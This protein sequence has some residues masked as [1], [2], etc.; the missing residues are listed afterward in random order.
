MD[1]Y[2]FHSIELKWQKRWDEQGIYEVHEDPGKKKFYCLEM[3]PYPSGQLH[4]GHVRNY[5][6]A[7]VVAR[8]YAMNGYNVLHPMGW[9]A[10]GMP[11]ENAAIKHGVHPADWTYENIDRMRAQLRRLGLSYDWSREVCTCDP[12]YYRWTQWMF[13][14][15]FHRGLAYKKLAP[16]NWCPECAT[17]LANEQVID[18]RCWRCDSLVTRKELDQWFFRITE[19][20]DRLLDDLQLLEGWP[21]RVRIMQSNWI[22][23]SEGVEL[24][25]E[26][27]KT[28]DVIPV[29]TTRPDTVCGVTY[30]VLAAEHPLVSKLTSGTEY[31]EA[32]S[33][34]V[35]RVRRVDLTGR[36][37]EVEKEGMFI[38]QYAINPVNRER[39][40]IWIANYVLMEYGT[41]AVMGVPAHDQRDFE[42]ARKYGLPINVVIVPPSDGSVESSALG[43]GSGLDRAYEEP[44]VMVNSG[45]FNGLDSATGRERVA[46]YVAEL[47]LGRRRTNYRLRDWLISRQ[48]YWGAPIPIVYCDS[49]GIVPVPESDLPVMLPRNVEFRPEGLSPL[50]SCEE[51]VNTTCPE[52]GMRA[53][54]E[55]DTMDTFV[56]SSWYYLRYCSPGHRDGPF[57]VEKTRYWMPVDQ[58]IGGIEH[59]VLHLLYSR[60]FTKA[61]RDAGYL[62]VDEPFARLLTQGMVTKDGAAMSKSRGNVVVPDDIVEKYGADTTRIF[63][64]FAAP[65]EKDLEWSDRG[66]EGASRF[67]NRVWRLV[68]S[69]I[70]EGCRVG[71]GSPMRDGDAE[72]AEPRLSDA[73]VG[74]KRVIH[75][76]IKKVTEDIRDRFNFNTALSAIMELT[77]A[78]S[79]YREEVSVDRRNKGVL[80]EAIRSL[81]VLLAPFAPHISEELWSGLGYRESVHRAPWPDYDPDAI[82][83]EEVT[84]V[85][86]I[87]GKVR[88]RV[89]VPVGTDEEE[90]KRIV[91]SRERLQPFL[92]GFAVDRFVVVPD[93]LV[94]IV[95]A[96]N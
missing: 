67:L 53:R 94:N 54:R 5:T 89:S 37:E 27:E 90:L 41:G 16:V 4:M 52:C 22:G 72:G 26:V 85:V 59:A 17:V 86:Q 66:V 91:F 92:R 20:S 80:T 84:L 83:S 3:F 46:E 56:C 45:Q 10:F 40:P 30:L 74:L 76:T 42:F 96:R 14:F 77:N 79:A 31:E 69:S 68:R 15:M 34:F 25:F 48:R 49:C 8:F 81:V 9:D 61:L 6:I 24:D 78:I 33:E 32:V 18:G 75:S 43:D 70:E 47:G 23:R 62:E 93:K 13:L 38:G 7:D 19:Y 36:L 44:G 12:E 60:F 87:D 58:Y 2:D 39:V 82:A 95:R 71:T 63:V 35:A 55:T 50:A 21:E 88:D 65:P 28:G 29:F 51:F 57:A 73:D 1:H 64:L 11:A